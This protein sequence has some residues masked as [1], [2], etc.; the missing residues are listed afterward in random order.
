MTGATETI[1]ENFNTAL[2]GLRKNEPAFSDGAMMRIPSSNSRRV[3]AFA[4]VSGADKFLVML[5]C[6]AKAFSGTIDLSS[7]GLA[8]AGRITLTD[9]FTKKSAVATVPASGKVSVKISALG[10]RILRLQQELPHKALQ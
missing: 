7:A 8:V 4:R 10:F 9:V 3:Y 5:N 6:S 1:S 2:F